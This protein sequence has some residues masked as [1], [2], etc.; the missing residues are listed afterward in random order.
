MSLEGL[1][2]HQYR[3]H[4]HLPTEKRSP[5]YLDEEWTHDEMMRDHDENHKAFNKDS[6]IIVP[7]EHKWMD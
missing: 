2:T 3:Y 1:R 4:R 5:I 6:Y 7:H